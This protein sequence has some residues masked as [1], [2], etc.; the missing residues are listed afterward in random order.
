VTRFIADECFSGPMFIALVAS[1]FD[2]KRSIETH[3]GASDAIILAYAR[4]ERR[5]LLTEDKDFGE[6]ILRL[7]HPAFGTVRVV[8]KSMSR[9]ARVERVVAALIELG[10]KVENAIVL[11]EPGR[12]RIRPLLKAE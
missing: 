2:V 12:V 9:E 10:D 3:A 5:V 1:G 11:I 7:G 4:Q 6:L 8:L